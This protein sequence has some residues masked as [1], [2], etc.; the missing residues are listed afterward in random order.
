[1]ENLLLTSSCF[2]GTYPDG[3]EYIAPEFEVDDPVVTRTTI[4]TST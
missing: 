4:I 2:S 1:M 3:T